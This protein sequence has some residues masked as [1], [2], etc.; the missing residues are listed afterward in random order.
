MHEQFYKSLYRIRRVEEELARNYPTDKIKSPVHLSIGQEAVSV[1]VCQALGPHDVVFGTYRGH[2]MYLA[3]GGNLKAMVAEMYGKATGCTKGKGGSMHL[4]DTDAGVMGTSA[5]VGTTIANAVG[6]AYAMKLRGEKGVVAS[7]FGDGASEEGVFYESLNFAVLK[8]LPI[9]F[10]CENNGYAIHTH[11]AR[12]QGLPK[13]HE[14]ART[15]GMPAEVIEDNDCLALHEQVTEAV[16]GLRG[17]TLSGPF[18]FE[19]RTSRWREHV[20]PNEDFHLGYRTKAELQPWVDNDQVVR[21][22]KLLSPAR[23]AQI[24]AAVEAEVQQAFAFADASPFPDESE[25]HTDVFHTKAPA[26]LLKKVA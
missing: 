5:V 26:P 8:K 15:F 23:R 21:I 18:F 4:V 7:F 13:I 1:A 16:V 3:K 19:C 24:E 6:C 25:L 17:G 14:R 9:V 2:A 10:I 22:G 12:R 20:G 11:Q